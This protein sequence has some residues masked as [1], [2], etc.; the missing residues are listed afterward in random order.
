MSLLRREFVKLLHQ[1]RTYFGW[2]IFFVV[3][4]LIY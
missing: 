3:P 1:K 2:A 4:F